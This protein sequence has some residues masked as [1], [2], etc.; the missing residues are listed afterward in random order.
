[1]KKTKFFLASLLAIAL[2]SCNLRSPATSSNKVAESSLPG[3]SSNLLTSSSEHE[4]P[5][6]S[7]NAQ[8]SSTQKSSSA[9][10]A[11]SSQQPTSSS[12][13][14][15]SSSQQPVS[16]S[17]PASSSQ[18]S[19]PSSSS[20][21]ASSSNPPA[22]SSS[23]SQPSS[24]N[25][26]VKPT[27]G[28]TTIDIFATNDIHGTIS[29]EDDDEVDIATM[30]TF[31]KAKGEMENTL[32]LDQGDTWQGS[33]YSNFN[34]GAL[35]TDIFNYVHY[36]ARTIGNHDFDW[37][38]EALE[39]NSARSFEGYRVPVLAANVY[40]YNFDTK[41]FGSTQQSN[42]GQSTVTYTL[43]NGVKVG[44]VGIIGMSQITSINS[45]YTHDIGFLDHIA[46]LKNE[47][48]ALRREGCDVVIATC[49]TG[50]AEVMGQ[51]LSEY[52]DLVLCAHT[53]LFEHATEDDLHFLQFGSDNRGVGKVTLTFDYETNSV[54]NTTYSNLLKS[55]IES[56]VTTVDSTVTRMITTY[57]AECDAEA[58]VVVA[59]NVSGTFRSNQE[60][61]NLMAKAIYDQAVSEGQDVVLSY[62]NNART[63]LGPGTWTYADLYSAF[64]FD[65]TIY[66]MDISGYDLL[67][68]VTNYNWAYRNPSF[69]QP[70]DSNS[71]YRVA[72]LD[73][74]GFHTNDRRSYNYF[75]SANGNY[76]ATLSKNYRLILRDWL[77]AH[78]YD[79]GAVL[80]SNSYTSN[81]LY[82][83]NAYK[84]AVN[85]YDGDT[86]L[87]TRG[88]FRGS[89]LLDVINGYAP[90]KIGYEFLN[91]SKE[92]SYNSAV[93]SEDKVDKY[94]IN[95]Y[96]NYQPTGGS[97][98]VEGLVNN[99]VYD[100]GSYIELNL[101]ETKAISLN[102]NGH[103]V[104]P[105]DVV[106]DQ[107]RLRTHSVD[108]LVLVGGASLGTSV[109][110]LSL[111]GQNY[112]FLFNV[113][114]TVEYTNLQQCYEMAND[115][116]ANV[117]THED[118][119]F[120][121]KKLSFYAGA[122][123]VDSSSRLI[124]NMAY[125]AFLIDSFYLYDFAEFTWGYVDGSWSY[126]RPKTY[127][128]TGITVAAGYMVSADR[129]ACYSYT[130]SRTGTVTLEACYGTLLSSVQVLNN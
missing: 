96:A 38:I 75:P 35:L 4:T 25:T 99:E 119:S 44:I 16:S 86:L 123:T 14:P 53:H 76:V 73:Y 116:W 71:T 77:I 100:F 81:G 36:D 32:L 49:H 109:V 67:N 61:P 83:R 20:Q 82:A 23:A 90:Y 78:D 58:N 24:S 72:L 65:N 55:D 1:M 7:S 74:L 63:D 98:T 12:Q 117:R 21:P 59:N 9:Q 88:G 108:G 31:L 40:D 111:D 29:A 89:Y 64:P 70:I 93:T 87:E 101:N 41:Q 94:T 118:G 8:S 104:A 30:A 48:N 106:A 5:E 128:Q 129:G 91:W 68:E 114:N 19:Q 28:S 127:L 69:T 80:S 60:A 22:S 95:L 97:A 39:Q 52:F 121:T 18:P 122:V 42:I 110:T 84:T 54:T 2:S 66:I 11:S 34:H 57:S 33:I 126:A 17:Q 6:S 105:S 113:V 37:G 92:L 3:V 45:L 103:T 43:E 85:F 51:N 112:G 50:Q 13:Q 47:A 79:K 115:S 62:V 26:P 124:I 27:T 56:N 46:V 120:F 15:A 102:A 125:D 107:T 130:N 10:P